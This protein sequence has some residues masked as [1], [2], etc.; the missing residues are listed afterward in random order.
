MDYLSKTIQSYNEQTEWHSAKFEGY[1]WKEYL[2]RF[3]RL[4]GGRKILDLGCGNGRDL[5][6]FYKQN[7]DAIGIDYSTKLIKKT[8]DRLPKVKILRMNFLKKLRFEDEEFDGMW[9]SASLLHVPKKSLDNVLLE[10]KRVLRDNGI[11]FVSVKVGIGE[12][13]VKDD[14]G[15]GSRFFSFFTKEELE[16]KLKNFGFDIIESYILSD[17]KLRIHFLKKK[18][19]Q[20]WIVLYC[21]KK[22]C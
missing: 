10:I 2:E 18:T 8:R 15:G 21:R 3:V 13:I 20:N 14:H 5:E 1:D 11:L 17:D 12:K 19:E 9:A 4:I 22:V 6:F 7:F 16:D